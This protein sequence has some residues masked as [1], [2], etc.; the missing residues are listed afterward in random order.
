M[1]TLKSEEKDLV[2]MI[3]YY[4]KRNHASEDPCEECAKL[5]EYAKKRILQNEESLKEYQI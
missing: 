4:C 3:K 5:I 2:F 1:F